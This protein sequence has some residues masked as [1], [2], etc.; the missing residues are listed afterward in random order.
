MTGESVRLVRR[1]IRS[2]RSA[3]I[4]GILFALM[5]II[6]LFLVSSAFTSPDSYQAWF[7]IHSSIS[8]MVLLLVVLSGVAFLWFTG[9]IRDR[10]G[11]REDRFFATIFFGSGILYV[12]M[13]FV[14]A[15][16]LGAILGIYTSASHLLADNDI[17]IFGFAT[18][19]EIINNFGLRMAGVY[20]TSINTL[21][22]RADV[23]PRWLIIITYILAL[24]FLFFAEQLFAARFLFPTWIFLVSAYILILNYRRTQDP[25]SENI[26]EV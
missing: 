8:S 2:P 15:A 3:A 20:M 22:A 12:G 17:Y 24:G 25:E 21:W 10:I 11:D 23:M 9:V 4:A 14:W 19:N 13:G 5:R 7:E 16:I 1:E 18:M 26:L 6:S